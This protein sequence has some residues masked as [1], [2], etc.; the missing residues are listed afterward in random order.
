MSGESHAAVPPGRG[1]APSRR[2]VLP[3]VLRGP[4]APGRARGATGSAS[5][6]ARPRAR[7]ARRAGAGR[8]QQ[9]R[10]G[11]AWSR[12]T[13]SD[14]RARP[15]WRA[16]ERTSHGPFVAALEAEFA[17][18]NRRVKQILLR[19]QV[20]VDRT[21][22]VPNDHSDARYDAAS[23]SPICV[24]RTTTPTGCCAPRAAAPRYASLRRRLARRAGAGAG[25]RAG[26]GRGRGRRELPRRRGGSC[27]PTCSP[28]SDASAAKPTREALRPVSRAPAWGSRA[29]APRARRGRVRR[30]VSTCAAKTRVSGRKTRTPTSR[31]GAR[32][33]RAQP[34]AP[35][36]PSK[37][38]R[39]GKT[40]ERQVSLSSAQQRR[41]LIS[42]GSSRWKRP[43]VSRATSRVP[44]SAVGG[45]PKKT[46]TP[47]YD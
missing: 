41:R 10:G 7:A 23:R 29:G 32:R 40:A 5:A 38:K 20:R 12:C 19:W 14:A 26:R 42:S 33:A 22:E 34:R 47:G 30:V 16:A 27:T 24:P 2:D 13:A 46:P 1:A 31:A 4:L 8:A 11:R 17:R 44:A 39:L 3:A 28:S 36:P 6:V 15:P 25:G 37:I 35:R 21:T 18:L 43:I 9:V 45:T